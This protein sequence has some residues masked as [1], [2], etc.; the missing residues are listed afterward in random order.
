MPANNCLKTPEDKPSVRVFQG[1]LHHRDAF[2]HA[3]A[4]RPIDLL[5]PAAQRKRL[6]G[7]V[8]G[9]QH[10]DLQRIHHAR[11]FGYRAH[12]AIDE[13]GQLFQIFFIPVRVHVVALVVNFYFHDHAPG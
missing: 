13:I 4:Q 11:R 2:F 1:L 3:L 10:R 7:D 8:Q 5:L 12:F 9:S 6:I